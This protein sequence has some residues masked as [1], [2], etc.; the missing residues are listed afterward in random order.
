[1]AD[2]LIDT[3][4]AAMNDAPEDDA[5]RLRFYDALASSE[6]FLML[7]KEPEGENIEPEVFEVQDAAF[8][9]VFDREDRISQFAGRPVPYAAL[10]GRALAQM[11]AGQGIGIAL[12]PEVAPSEFLLPPEGVN[13]LCGTLDHGPQEREARPEKLAAPMGLPQEL[14]SS[15]DAKLASAAGLA[16]SAYLAHVTYDDGSQGHLLGIT[17]AIPEAQRA[18]AGAVNDALVFSGLEAGML[19]VAFVEDSD[20]LTAEL[21]RVALRFDLPEAPKAPTYEPVTPGSDPD[22]PPI[23]K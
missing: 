18:L 15:L 14:L 22:S 4:F 9:L 5:A 16:R 13:W 21:A 2:T 10:P 8:V 6:L 1:M 19:D 3:A 20:I 12:N 23:L 17:G 7:S 11:L